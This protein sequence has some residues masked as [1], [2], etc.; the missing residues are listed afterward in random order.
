MVSCFWF[1]A[2]KMGQL[3]RKQ[4][5]M[6]VK[7]WG[8]GVNGSEWGQEKREFQEIHPWLFLKPLDNV[9]RG[10]AW[11]CKH[12]GHHVPSAPNS[13]SSSKV[14]FNLL[15]SF[16]YPDSNPIHHPPQSTTPHLPPHLS[17]IFAEHKISLKIMK[18]L[19]LSLSLL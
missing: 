18:K 11:I 3:V 10:Q 14:V 15:T 7:L 1:K 12:G 6:E 5:Y 4:V 9:R 2:S 13:L 8:E 16:L 19:S 17:F